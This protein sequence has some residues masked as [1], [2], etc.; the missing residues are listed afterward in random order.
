[1]IWRAKILFCLLLCGAVFRTT[2]DPGDSVLLIYNSAV[3]ASKQI[4]MHYAKK[5]H[6]PESQILSFDLPETE[7]ISGEDYKKRLQDPLWE[8]LKKRELFTFHGAESQPSNKVDIAQSK[9]R[10]AVLCYGVPVKI[11]ADPMLDEPGLDKTPVELRR[12]EASVD[13]ELAALPA[14]DLKLKLAGPTSNPIFSTTNSA[15]INPTNGVLMVARLDG[16]TPEIALALVDKALEAETNGLWGRAY[17]DSRGLTNGAYLVG[18]QWMKE[19][20]EITRGYGYDTIIDHAEPTFPSSFPMPEIA[21]YFGWYAQDISG[22]FLSGLAEFRP[23]AIAYHLHSFSARQLR[24]AT[25]GWAGPLLARGATA[26]MG[27]TEEPY[28]QMTPD[29]PIFLHRLIYLGFTFGEAAYASQ[30]ALSWQITVVG[31]PLYRPFIK[32]QKERFDQLEASKDRNLEWSLM[33][34]VQ[35]R[36]AHGASLDEI[37]A[38]YAQNPETKTS[39]ILEEKLGDVY[40]SHGKIFNAINPYLKALSLPC[41]P[42]EKLRMTLSAGTLLSRLGHA[43]EAYQLYKNILIAFPNYPGKKEIYERL[44]QVAV[45][46]KKT[47][48]AAEYQRLSK[49]G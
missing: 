46:L 23:G 2:A 10:Y 27:S 3:P 25:S 34:W 14:L 8:E 42:L 44:A 28:L 16:P 12:N 11:T 22:P 18:D 19:G 43:E 40:K 49:E 20:A 47:G 29:I 4:A 38:F 24:T 37:E 1:M 33:M 31:D 13:S 41:S 36:L 30:R 48:E 35:F 32:S 26:T 9:I 21:F 7:T 5:R 17:F 6:V 15:W 39:A 45:E